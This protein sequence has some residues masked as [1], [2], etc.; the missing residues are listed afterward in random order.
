MSRMLGAVGRKRI[1]D[2]SI[3]GIFTACGLVRIVF[4]EDDEVIL[5]Q[6]VLAD[7]PQAVLDRVGVRPDVPPA[8]SGLMS[9]AQRYID[10][11]RA[12]QRALGPVSFKHG[13]RSTGAKPSKYVRAG[14]A[15]M[16]LGVVALIL[17]DW[18]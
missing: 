13:R 15:T 11:M 12:R 2:S 5:R 8:S 6:E 4:D 7:F 14:K 18:L 1:L 3:E 16:I 17:T 10:Q 9:S